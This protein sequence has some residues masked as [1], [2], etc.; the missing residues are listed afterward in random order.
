M[1]YS[2]MKRIKCLVLE[3]DSNV[4]RFKDPRRNIF[5]K[6]VLL[7]AWQL[8][9]STKGSREIHPESIHER[10]KKLVTYKESSPSALNT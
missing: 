7:N 2:R 1:K 3:G 9:F 6:D 4:Y 10:K 5:K 8:N